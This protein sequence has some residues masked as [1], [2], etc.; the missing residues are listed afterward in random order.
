MNLP[1]L[2]LARLCDKDEDRP[3]VVV[4]LRYSFLVPEKL[5]GISDLK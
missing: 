3:A 1:R 5:K 2:Q 4:R